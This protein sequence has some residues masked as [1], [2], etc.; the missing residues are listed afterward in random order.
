MTTSVIMT[1]PSDTSDDILRRHILMCLV[2][3]LYT[4]R[5]A[6][7]HECHVKCCLINL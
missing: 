5:V 1:W 7:A 4:V 3:I 2:H 6:S